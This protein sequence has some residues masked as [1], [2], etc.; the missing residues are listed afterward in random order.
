MKRFAILFFIGS[1]IFSFISCGNSRLLTKKIRNKNVG[2]I[3]LA[4]IKNVSKKNIEVFILQAWHYKIKI[5]EINDTSIIEG[6]NVNKN[7]SFSFSKNS[8]LD[9]SREDCKYC[10]KNLSIKKI[11]I[12]KLH[13]ALLDKTSRKNLKNLNKEDIV[14]INLNQLEDTYFLAG[15]FQFNRFNCNLLEKK[16]TPCLRSDFSELY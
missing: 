9:R 13:K 6:D 4:Q 7:S 12:D 11:Y 15:I 2:I 5:K 8:Y 14:L 3:V 10:F 16:L 1:I